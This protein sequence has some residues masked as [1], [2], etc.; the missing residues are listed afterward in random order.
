MLKC[1]VAA[2]EVV[3]ASILKRIVVGNKGVVLSLSLGGVI[4]VWC[5]VVSIVFCPFLI[6][7]LTDLSSVSIG[8]V[9][10][11]S[12]WIVPHSLSRVPIPWEGFSVGTFVIV[13]SIGNR[14]VGL[15]VEFLLGNVAQGPVLNYRTNLLS[16]QIL[17]RL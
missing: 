15:Y 1:C 8:V 6:D 4:I 14:L 3:G 13:V 2:T 16:I 10:S 17:G 9:S 12:S 7:S 5:M 11:S